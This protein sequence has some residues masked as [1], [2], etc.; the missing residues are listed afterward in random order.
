MAFQAWVL[1]AA[2]VAVVAFRVDRIQVV[3]PR[4][5]YASA[6]T[7]VLEMVPRGAKKDP[8]QKAQV[9]PVDRVAQAVMPAPE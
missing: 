7:V 9:V 3:E 4:H 1:P 2:E 8:Q 5:P 6:W